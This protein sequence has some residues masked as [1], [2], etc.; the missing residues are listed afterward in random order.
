M[1]INIG[2]EDNYRGKEVEKWQQK[3]HIESGN[4]QRFYVDNVDKLFSKEGFADF[5]NVSGTHGYQQIT[6]YTIF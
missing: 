1:W 4:H 3:I 6:V 2:N 5:N